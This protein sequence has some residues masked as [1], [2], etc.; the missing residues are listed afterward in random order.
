MGQAFW[1]R[2]VVNSFAVFNEVC[3]SS[4]YYFASMKLKV[5]YGILN[6]YRVTAGVVKVAMAICGFL[7]QGSRDF[8]LF[9]QRRLKL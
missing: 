6:V 8:V 7:V 1:R 5:N 2:Y 4:A 3:V 9:E